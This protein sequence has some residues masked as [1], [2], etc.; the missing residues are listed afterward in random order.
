[1]AKLWRA[2]NG[3]I[4]DNWHPLDGIAMPEVAPDTWTGPHVGKRFSEAF[5]TLGKLPMRRGPSRFGN[6][7][8]AHM[9]EW[10]DQI[11]QQEQE[12]ADKQAQADARNRVRLLPSAIEI[13]HCEQ[14]IGWPAQFLK[15]R[16]TLMRS[17]NWVALAHCL[18][19]DIDWLTRRF[20]GEPDTCQQRHWQGCD[21]IADGLRQARVTVW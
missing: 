4:C 12:Q 13:G 8:P 18:E 20:G 16:P 1:M 2:Y 7:W 15:D 19:R 14:A 21:R 6:H 9:V 17:V 3:V 5:E 10:A 11:A